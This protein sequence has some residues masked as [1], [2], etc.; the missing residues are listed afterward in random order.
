[1]SEEFA[2]VVNNQ[3]GAAEAAIGQPAYEAQVDHQ[4][5]NSELLRA[6]A[7]HIAAQTA[8]TQAQTELHRQEYEHKAKIIASDP[9]GMIKYADTAEA[10]LAK[11]RLII[12]DGIGVVCL[13]L[14]VAI[15]A[16]TINYIIG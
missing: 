1:M 12:S 14:A 3:W 7:G 6:Q 16:L 8:A 2:N 5:A 13:A 15:I 4:K 10:I 9:E 11:S